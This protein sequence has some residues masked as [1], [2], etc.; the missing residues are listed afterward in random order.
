V[1]A[2][3]ASNFRAC[4][5][6]QAWWL[7]DASG[8]LFSQLPPASPPD[9]SRSAYLRVNGRRSARGQYGHLGAYAYELTV[10]QVLEVASD[11]SGKCP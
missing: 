4:G 9:F 3:E 11:T 7:T 6:T 8:T 10:D 1:T 5:G 2:F